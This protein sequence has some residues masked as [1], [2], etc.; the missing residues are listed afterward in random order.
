MANRDRVLAELL[1]LGVIWGAAFSFM[2]V[3][4]PESG[5]FA[6]VEVRIG[7]AALFLIGLL[8][9]RGGLGT[10]AARQCQCW[11]LEYSALHRP[12]RAVRLTL[13]PF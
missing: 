8:A 2:R 10:C 13:S 6:L 5:A 9:W 12:S 1:I 3:A 11:W 4:V 7:I